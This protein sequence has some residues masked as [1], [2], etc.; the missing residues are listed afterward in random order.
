MHP[1]TGAIC[2]QYSTSTEF[3][4]ALTGGAL[5]RLIGIYAGFFDAKN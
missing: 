2:A 4:Q 5:E 3:V 1:L